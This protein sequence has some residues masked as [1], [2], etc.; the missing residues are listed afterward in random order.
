MIQNQSNS[1]FSRAFLAKTYFWLAIQLLI[2][3]NISAYIAYDQRIGEMLYLGHFGNLKVPSP[4]LILL[5]LSVI[6]IIISS[7]RRSVDN[8]FEHL[9]LK[10][11]LS[12]TLVGIFT[13]IFWY[14]YDN[15]SILHIL[16]LTCLMFAILS[17]VSVIFTRMA[18]KFAYIS[19]YLL[20]IL[21]WMIYTNF[22]IIKTSSFSLAVTLFG[23]LVFSVVIFTDTAIYKYIYQR[24]KEE[25]REKFAFMAASGLYWN[26][27]NIF[28]RLLNIFGS[29]K[30]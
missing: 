8:M 20:T 17:V 24:V 3:F 2:T 26:F 11:V 4:I 16:G 28:V 18:L 9:Y 25:D 1:N 23:V 29:K 10:A 12:I 30:K 14:T 21:F 15:S 5:F 22:L 7:F 6:A 27:V 13:S 19:S